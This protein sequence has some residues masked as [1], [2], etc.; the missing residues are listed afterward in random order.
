MFIFRVLRLYL[1]GII[2]PMLSTHYHLHFPLT[3]KTTSEA[4][5]SSTNQRS[6]GNRTALDISIKSSCY[7]YG[8]IS[9]ILISVGWQRY[10]YKP[11]IP[12]LSVTFWTS[13]FLHIR[14]HRS[15]TIPNVFTWS[16]TLTARRTKQHT[17]CWNV[18]VLRLG[19]ESNRRA[20]TWG[21]VCAGAY[22]WK[23]RHYKGKLQPHQTRS[24]IK[25]LRN[26]DHLRNTWTRRSC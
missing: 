7:N 19:Y 11:S 17:D 20:A 10:G 6:F 21:V 12:S 16:V 13:W 22:K 5:E 25:P 3:I 26:E 18:S 2:L 23:A 15:L 14:R 24:D 9:D 8:S 4:W 1:V